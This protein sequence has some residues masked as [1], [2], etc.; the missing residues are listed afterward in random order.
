MVSEL[1]QSAVVVLTPDVESVVSRLRGRFDSSA[2]EG[3]PAHI[4]LLFPFVVESRMT[5]EVDAELRAICAQHES[6]AVT[7]SR[8]GRFP[9]LLYLAPDPA[10]ELPRADALDR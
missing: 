7:F 1:G 6:I 2:T 4:T 8:V 3:M 10:D 9:G 5:A